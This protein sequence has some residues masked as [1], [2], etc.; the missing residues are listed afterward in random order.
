MDEWRDP[1]E[2]RRDLEREFDL[3]TKQ[4]GHGLDRWVEANAK[5]QLATTRW[6][7]VVSALLSVVAISTITLILRTLR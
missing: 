3:L 5:W 4:M 2:V 1:T 6:L 7:M